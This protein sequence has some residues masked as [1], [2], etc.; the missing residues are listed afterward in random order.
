MLP[1]HDFLLDFH[2]QSKNI[3]LVSCCSGHGFKFSSVLGKDAVE[4][5]FSGERKYERFNF[6]R[7]SYLKFPEQAPKL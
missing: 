1:D 4:M 7:L 6:R 2:P 5:S 3:V